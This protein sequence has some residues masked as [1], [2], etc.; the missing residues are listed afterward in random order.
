VSFSVLQR[1]SWSDFLPEDVRMATFTP[2]T[3]Q[4]VLSMLGDLQLFV[5]RVALE[6]LTALAQYGQF[7][8]SP[9]RFMI[10]LSSRGCPHDNLHRRDN[11]TCRVNARGFSVVCAPSGP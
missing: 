7:L 9:E 8:C 2:D 1:D 6:T 11:A 5:R 4:N 3:M 10:R